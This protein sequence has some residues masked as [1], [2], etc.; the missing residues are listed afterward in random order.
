MD[1]RKQ[2][3]VVVHLRLGL[4]YLRYRRRLSSMPTS[5]DID[6]V[7]IVPVLVSALGLVC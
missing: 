6:P 5:M 4:E 7:L 1:A 2:R 3:Q